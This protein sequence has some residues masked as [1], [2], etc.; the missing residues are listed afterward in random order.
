MPGRS[1]KKNDLGWVLS[2]GLA[3]SPRLSRHVG[4]RM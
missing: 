4:L 2:A 3:H 1:H